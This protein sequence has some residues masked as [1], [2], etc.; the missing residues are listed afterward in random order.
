MTPATSQD[1]RLERGRVR[2]SAP[3]ILGSD[4]GCADGMQ[5]VPI[6]DADRI[7]AIEV[8]CNGCQRRLTV[9]CV[10]AEEPANHEDAL[11]SEHR[12]RSSPA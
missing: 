3:V 4:D 8:Q 12:V 1:T 10:Y 2:L 5:V 7:V 9:E 11:A 6:V